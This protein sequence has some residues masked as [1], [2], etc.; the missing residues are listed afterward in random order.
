MVGNKSKVVKSKVK[1]RKV[2]RIEVYKE[3]LL[4]GK[5]ED[6]SFAMYTKN[7]LCFIAVSWK[8]EVCKENSLLL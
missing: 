8:L 4:S 7:G 5:M 6:G 1:S 3:L 2:K